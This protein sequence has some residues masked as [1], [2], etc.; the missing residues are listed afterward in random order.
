MHEDGGQESGSRACGVHDLAHVEGGHFAAERPCGVE[1][2][3]WSLAYEHQGYAAIQQHPGSFLDVIGSEQRR[4]LV[5]AQLDDGGE[6][7]KRVHGFPCGLGALPQVLAEVD[8]EGYGDVVLAGELRDAVRRRADGLADE[9]D[10]AEVYE[11]C[12]RDQIF[13]NVLGREQL[14]GGRTGP[15][16]CELTVP[17]GAY[18][19][20][21]QRGAGRRTVAA[22][23][24]GIHTLGFEGP[25]DEVSEEILPDAAHESGLGAKAAGGDCYVRG[26]APR[27]GDEPQLDFRDLLPPVDVR[28]DLAQ[29]Y[30]LPQDFLPTLYLVP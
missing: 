19:H 23:T 8:V 2:A 30:Y 24:G 16:E 5:V 9:G 18:L 21:G 29:R 1:R 12:S 17:V 3:F 10:A 28:D 7:Q 27:S 11:R 22:Y 15:V 13:R 6:V 14:V 4:E 25:Q 20:E 26:R